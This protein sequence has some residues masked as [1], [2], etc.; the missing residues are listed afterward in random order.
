MGVYSTIFRFIGSIFVFI[1]NCFIGLINRILLFWNKLVRLHNNRVRRGVTRRRRRTVEQ[2]FPVNL[3]V[4]N[5][6][7]SGGHK[8]IRAKCMAQIAYNAHVQGAQTIVIHENN[9][10]LAPELYAKISPKDV[11][12]IDAGHARLEPFRNYSSKEISRFLFDSATPSYDLKKNANYYV[13]GMCEFLY[14]KN[15]CPSLRS[16]N[17]CPHTQLFDKVDSLVMK[18]TINDTQG[19]EIKSKLMMGQ[20]EQ[21]KIES[22]IS[23]LYEQ[24]EPLLS[25]SHQDCHNI[26]SAIA[27]NKVLVIDI[28]SN[29][30]ELLINLLLNQIRQALSKCQYLTLITDGLSS[31]NSEVYKKILRERNDRCRLIVGGDD[32]Y[33]VCAADEKLFETL[34]GNSES[35]VILG[36]S[37]GTTCTRWANN[38][39]YY[40]K[41]EESQSYSR[42]MMRPSPFTAF[43]GSNDSVSKT[44]NMKREYI[45]TPEAINRMNPKEAYV[46]SHAQ[47]RLLHTSIK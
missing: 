14:H 22:L 45:V 1:W 40:D 44:Y 8:A 36:H 17:K 2:L 20:S 10:W 4:S 7:I 32:V 19:Q 13:E 38:I 3:P 31:A 5:T 24:A 29:T 6:V 27:Q 9:A 12:A 37:S 33:S 43:P 41:D 23:D 25:R 30:N 28:S 26:G 11:V 16:F 15:I 21:F 47:N 34:L 42:A 35:F 18:G 46:Y 39:G